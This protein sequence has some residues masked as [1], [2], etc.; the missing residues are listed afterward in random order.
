[1]RY[2]CWKQNK[3]KQKKNK[4]KK[5]RNLEMS[6]NLMEDNKSIS[7]EY[8]S[9]YFADIETVCPFCPFLNFH[10]LK[11]ICYDRINNLF[12][13]KFIAESSSRKL[14]FLV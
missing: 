4:K 2:L 5:N 14:F 7:F 9:L 3:T 1:M 10:T 6:E 12:F 11:N 8:L 13:N